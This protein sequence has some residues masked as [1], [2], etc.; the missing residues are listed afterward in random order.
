MS[1]MRLRN[2]QLRRVMDLV[3]WLDVLWSCHCE[4]N[5]ISTARCLF[6]GSRPPRQLRVE[7]EAKPVPDLD[8]LLSS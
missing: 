8:A 4:Y 5:N 1:A 2:R 7:V 6:C 3:R